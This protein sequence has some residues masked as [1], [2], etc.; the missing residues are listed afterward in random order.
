PSVAI[1]LNA[2][3]VDGRYLTPETVK[4]DV[5]PEADVPQDLELD[6]IGPGQI[7]VNLS[8]QH[9]GE[10]LPE[11][12]ILDDFL[13]AYWGLHVKTPV[14][15]YKSQSGGYPLVIRGRPGDLVEVCLRGSLHGFWDECR[16]EQLDDDRNAVANF[17]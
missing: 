8:I 3:S 17:D 6:V 5:Q 4:V 13:A 14:G 12:I 2:A 7:E 9:Y 10:E 16:T 15:T 11:P 1:T